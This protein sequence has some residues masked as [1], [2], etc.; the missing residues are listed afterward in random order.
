MYPMSQSISVNWGQRYYRFV[1]FK[2][3]KLIDID[4]DLL[5]TYYSKS[6]YLPMVIWIF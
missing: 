4:Q 5:T 3:K 2:C 6:K 1:Y